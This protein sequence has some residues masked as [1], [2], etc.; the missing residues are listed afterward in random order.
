[1][2]GIQGGAC[3]PL[4]SGYLHQIRR[5]LASKYRACQTLLVSFVESDLIGTLT[6]RTIRPSD[7]LKGWDL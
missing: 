1:M 7:V 4:T 3:S 5:Y 6:L 2:R